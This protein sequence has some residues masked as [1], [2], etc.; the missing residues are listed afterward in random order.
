MVE[1]PMSV[2]LLM[3]RIWFALLGAVGVIAPA[4]V[5]IDGLLGPCRVQFGAA[6]MRVTLDES[7]VQVIDTAFVIGSGTAGLLLLSA[8]LWA[9]DR[10]RP[11][12]VAA[13][14]GIATA[15]VLGTAL[16][17]MSISALAFYGPG[18]EPL[19]LIGGGLTIASWAA[20]VVLGRAW[21]HSRPTK[22]S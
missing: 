20:A 7:C 11:E 2:P 4:G 19:L 1:H 18:A 8:A 14:A 5:V 22:A 13:I 9:T 6:H 10:S 21:F 16:A 15:T 3:S 12:R 17:A